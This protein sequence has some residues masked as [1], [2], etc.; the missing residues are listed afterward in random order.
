MLEKLTPYF[1]KH[2]SSFIKNMFEILDAMTFCCSSNTTKIANSMTAK[3][4]KDFKTNDMALYRLLSSSSFQLDDKFWRQYN[5]IIFDMLESNKNIKKGD[6]LFV[7]VDFTSSKD[8]FLILCAS[9][10]LNNKINNK[11]SRAIPLYFSMRNYPKKKGQYDHKK[12][13]LAFLK[14]LKH[15]LSKH[16]SFVIVAD[17][18]FANNRFLENCEE[19][20][21]DYLIRTNTYFN[22]ATEDNKTKSM[23]KALKENGKYNVNIKKWNKNYFI[24]KQDNWF[25]L[26]NIEDLEQ[27]EAIKRYANRFKIEKVFQDL[28]SSGFDIEETKIKKYE[29][30]KRMF[31]LSMFAYSILLLLGN[32]IDNLR[33]IKKNSQISTNHL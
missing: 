20:N 2:K 29:R 4:S 6:K 14:A 28:K 16:Y 21:F 33:Y 12:M 3:N 9:I 32:V 22:I 27:C 11:N 19:C 15:I 25:L 18:G 8:D 23:E 7:Q 31:F 1:Q 13:E 17:R 30:F 26:S 10:V 5:N 24:H